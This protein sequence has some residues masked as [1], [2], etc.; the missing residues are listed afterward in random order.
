MKDVSVARTVSNAKS[1]AGP[2][3]IIA[4]LVVEE[5]KNSHDKMKEYPE[6]KEEL[7]AAFVDHPKIETLA[8]T[9]GFGGIAEGGIG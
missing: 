4:D 2:S 3:E 6:A 7:L 9:G 8:K 1:A 5:T